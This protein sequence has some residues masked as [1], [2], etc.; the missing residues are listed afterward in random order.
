MPQQQPPPELFIILAAFFC[1]IVA[2]VAR[3][4]LL[5]RKRVTPTTQQQVN[6]N[7]TLTNDEPTPQVVVSGNNIAL[8]SW[9]DHVNKQPNRV[10]HLA[11]IGPSGSGKTTLV[12]AVLSDRD[13]RIIV[14]TA[15]EGDDWGGLPYIG[16]DDDTS[17]TTMRKTFDGLYQEVKHR[18]IATK[19]NR[20]NS[21][22]LTIVVDDFSTLVKE[23]PVATNVVKLVARL[24]RSLR[25]RLIMLSDSALVKAIGLEGEGETRSNFA[26]IRLRRGHGGVIEIEDETHPIETSTLHQIAQHTNLANR[27]WMPSHT[28]MNGFDLGNHTSM[29]YQYDSNI[30][31][32]NATNGSMASMNER[33][34]AILAILYAN[35]SVSKNSIYAA[36]GGDRNAVMARIDVLKGVLT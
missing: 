35:P 19:H 20:M 5:I 23:C 32:M 22:W 12:T 7:A 13:G 36:V 11:V 31:D 25:V 30:P 21:D 9:L 29:P 2:G 24:G 4:F 33:D 1:A 8:R 28:D 15:K 27:K 14:L 26:F 17:Y 6:S 3:L 10:P 34:K 18:L 16:I